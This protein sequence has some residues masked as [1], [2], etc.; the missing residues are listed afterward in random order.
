MDYTITLVRRD[1]DGRPTTE[2]LGIAKNKGRAMTIAKLAVGKRA[3]FLGTYGPS[4]V[5]CHG[6]RGTAV[7]AW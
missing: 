3:H 4:A 1:D 2:T 7:V 6:Q 5:A